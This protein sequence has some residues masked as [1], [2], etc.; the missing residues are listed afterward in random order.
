[1]DLQQLVACLELSHST[2]L[3]LETLKELHLVLVE[4]E[5]K[6]DPGSDAHFSMG[7]QKM[8]GLP[9]LLRNPKMDLEVGSGNRQEAS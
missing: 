7:Q 3:A 2:Q 5:V 9:N 8:D 6:V 4:L 1:V